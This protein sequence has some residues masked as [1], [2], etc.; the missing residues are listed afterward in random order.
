LQHQIQ[1]TTKTIKQIKT[2]KKKVRTGLILSM[3]FLSGNSFAKT[4]EME[5]GKSKTDQV[6][7]TYLDLVMNIVGAN[8]N[9]GKYN[10]TFS[11]YKKS[12][13]G[14]Q[15]GASFQ[16]GITPTFSIISEM[17][18]ITKGGKLE[19]NNP[20]SVN[21]STLRL[22]TLESPFLV[23]FRVGKFYTNAGPSIAFNVSGTRKIEGSSTENLFKNSGGEIKRW[24]AGVQMGVGYKFKVKQKN[25]ALDI[26][27]SHGLTNI[28]KG[29]QEMY[30]RYV[31][32]SLH[33]SNPWKT[34]P[35]AK[36]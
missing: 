9:Y 35:F 27:Y 16:A 30:N 5:S 20:L 34:N 31:N 4:N 10:S 23:R 6:T 32:V 21:K 11:N 36:K 1:Q 25:V 7:E 33:I 13:I 26:R 3:I 8:L 18:L 22:Y 17:Y 19:A 28:S 24:D 14:S 29:R 15:I 2:M 12:V